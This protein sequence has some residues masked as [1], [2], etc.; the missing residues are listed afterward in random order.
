MDKERIQ[1]LG[2]KCYHRI[3]WVS[4]SEFWRS[5][6]YWRVSTDS[7][8]CLSNGRLQ[9]IAKYLFWNSCNWL[10]LVEW[11]TKSIQDIWINSFNSVQIFTF[12]PID[13]F[14]NLL[15]LIVYFCVDMLENGMDV[16]KLRMMII[17]K[18]LIR[19]QICF[20]TVCQE[21]LI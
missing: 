4:S 3:S 16:L 18:F 7:W 1:R 2:R 8:T 20:P 15:L 5:R 11:Y 17:H 9:V 13:L 19:G 6:I 12:V 14:A 21:E 10:A